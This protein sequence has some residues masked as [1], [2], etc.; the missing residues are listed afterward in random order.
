[1]NAELLLA[2]FDRMTAATDAVPRL[3]QFILALAVRGK[4]VE[5]DPKDES[6]HVLLDRLSKKALH[7]TGNNN[8]GSRKAYPGSQDVLQ[9]FAIPPSW[10]WT[11]VGLLAEKITDG[12][13]ISPTKAISG[14]PLLTATHVTARGL[15]F[16][17]PQYVSLE[18]G[19]LSR[20]RCDPR[21]GDILIC[22]RGTIGRCAI[23]DADEVFCLMGSVILLRLPNGCS[24][25][26]FK[27]YLS[28]SSAQIE[29]SGMSGATAVNALYLRDIRRCAVPV[30]P[31]QEQLR[32]VRKVD[33]LMALC[34][35]LEVAQRERESRRDLL[36]TS[37]YH[38]LNNG[39]GAEDLRACAKFLIDNFHRLTARPNQVKQLRQ[40]LYSLAV[41][42][43]LVAQDAGDEPPSESLKRIQSE[44]SALVQ[45]GALRKEKPLLPVTTDDA[46][47]SLPASWI[48]V[49]IGALS[50]FTDYGTSVQSGHA[51]RGVPV[52]KM[53]DIQ[54]GQ[55]ILGGQKKV[56]AEIDDL[57]DLFLKQLD[58][59]YNRTN[60]AELVGKTGIYMGEDDAYTFASYLI[61]IRLLNSETNPIYVNL[62]MNA[63]YFRATQI[64]PELQQQCGQANVNGTKLRNMLIALPPLAEQNRI[65]AKVNDLMQLCDHLENSLTTAQTETGRLLE[66]VLNRALSSDAIRALQRDGARSGMISN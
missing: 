61:R 66:S 8:L 42:G 35:R 33:E 7:E 20:K 36:T 64:V 16:E 6:G 10:K 62:A 9:P 38:H 31:F 45:S 53:G 14:M 19:T 56:P 21:K 65:V 41:R 54:D 4:L 50:T 60:S 57:P 34:D 43:L 55:V 15:S 48:W 18:D 46:P 1:M 5:Q 27:H 22:S 49:R 11:Q 25:H 63:P 24:P 28:T 2:Y 13:H 39:S 32:I 58:L 23:V 30:P 47:F 26:Y 12:E 37:T 51:D 17:N 59:L 3:R 40:T 44:K 52:L 29:M